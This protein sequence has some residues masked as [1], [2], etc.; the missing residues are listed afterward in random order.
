MCKDITS[1]EL[2]FICFGGLDWWY[3]NRAHIDFQ[4]M[5]RYSERGPV[6]YINSIMM[7]KFNL[8]QS[9]RLIEKLIRKTKSIFRGRKKVD[10]NFWVY[11]PV[12]LPVQHIKWARPLNEALLRLQ[13]RRVVLKMGMHNP[14]IWVVCP[15]ACDIAMKMKKNKLVYLR[16]DTYELFPNVDSRIIR[17]YDQK[18][19]A[20]AD[21][22]LF[23]SDKL[24]HEESN[25]C[26]KALYLDHGV[27]YG[28]FA[29]ADKDPS[30]P[31]D[32]KTIHRP[33]IGYFGAINGHTVDI[34][35]AEKIADLLP[36]MSFVYIG[37][38]YSHYPDLMA[39]KN[40][41]MLGQQPYEHIP[42]YGKCFDLA[43]MP[44]RQTQWIESCNPVKLKE[45]LALGKPIVSTPFGELQKYRDVVYVAQTPEDFAKCIQQALAED[46]PEYVAARR[47]KVQAATWDSKARLV[48]DELFAEKESNPKVENESRLN[49]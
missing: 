46:R 13:I 29:S 35:L 28:L 44:W 26:K 22:T 25:Q 14:V 18:L 2:S 11:S 30:K 23:V 49:C 4:L 47:K 21:L 6:I 37:A 3:H 1:K 32:I 36:E 7:Q 8:T 33:I 34:A 20:N 27:D 39:K 15:T 45:Y 12:S 17:N 40:V 16:T 10:T 43:I 5:R 48:L 24:F 9:R 41:W 19:K 38:G 31:A 42:H